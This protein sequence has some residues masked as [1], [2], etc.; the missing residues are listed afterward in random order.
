MLLYISNDHLFDVLFAAGCV[1]LIQLK[2]IN[3][4]NFDKGKKLLFSKY[5]VIAET[6]FGSQ[7]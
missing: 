5:N 3:N 6:E 4:D 1:L 7:N 2:F